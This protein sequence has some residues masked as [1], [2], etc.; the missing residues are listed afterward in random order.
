MDWRARIDQ[1]V[2]AVVIG[3]GVAI[4]VLFIASL[5]MGFAVIVARL[6]DW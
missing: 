6:G 4:G 5:V 2:G 3:L 1:A